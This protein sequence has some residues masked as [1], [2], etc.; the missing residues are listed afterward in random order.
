[1]CLSPAIA[2]LPFREKFNDALHLSWTTFTTVGYGLISPSTG[3][4]AEFLADPSFFDQ[5]GMCLLINFLMS[6]ES[7]IG[8]LF[9]GLC[10]AILFGKL[11]SFQSNAKVAFSGVMAVNFGE[12]E[13]VEEEDDSDASVEEKLTEIRPKTYKI[14]CPILRFRI[15]N[16]LHSNQSGEITDAALNVFATIDAKNSILAVKSERV[17]G[18]A[19]Q[20][21][22]SEDDI[23]SHGSS[24]IRL[25]AVLKKK[26]QATSEGIKTLSRGVKH[27]VRHS[28]SIAQPTRLQNNYSLG[29]FHPTSDVYY[30]EETN[31]DQPNLVFTNVQVEPSQH[32]FFRA[33][34]VVSH[35]L[36]A[37]SPLLKKSVR[38]RVK[39]NNGFWPEDLQSVEGI[40]DSIHFDQFLVSFSGSSKIAGGTVYRQKIYTMDNLKIG[41]N[42]KSLL[43]RNP[44]NTL[45]VRVNDIDMVQKQRLDHRKTESYFF[46]K[47]YQ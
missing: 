23:S 4:R 11:M 36:D 20:I 45:F 46:E 18:N 15:A 24:S 8:V 25:S 43:M 6:F 22:G 12:K 37:T 17:F 13:F 29:Y 35:V 5:E 30:Q 32:P 38:D 16:E 19:M 42:F 40:R 14:T 28:A 1:L 7:L 34:W 39:E 3:G 27:R 9:V 26:A 31:M 10:S 2:E 44:D 21:V 33:T 41:Y 47:F